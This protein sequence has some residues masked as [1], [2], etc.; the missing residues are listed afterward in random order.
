M[1]L[2]DCFLLSDSQFEGEYFGRETLEYVCVF[3]QRR[4][5][6]RLPLATSGQERQLQHQQVIEGQ[7]ALRMAAVIVAVGEVRLFQGPA[8]IR[9]VAPLQH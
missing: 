5:E 9:Q 6:G 1:N 8:E 4:P 2:L 7:T 3:R